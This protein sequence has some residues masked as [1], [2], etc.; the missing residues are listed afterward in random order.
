MPEDQR[1]EL[2]RN[3]SLD[4][5]L[6]VLRNSREYVLFC[7]VMEN[8]V[9]RDK[10]MRF[11]FFDKERNIL[12]LT[13]TDIMEV[14]EEERQRQLLQDALQVAKSANQAKSDFLSRMSHDI[15]TPMNAIIGMTTIASMHIDDRERIVDCLKK[16]MVSSKLLLNLI[17][18]VLDMSKVESG[19]ILLTDEEFDMGELLQSVITMVQTSVSQKFQDFRV[20][21]F[22]VKHEKLIGDVQRIQQV[23]LNLLSNAIKYTPD[24]GK[25]TLEIREKPIKMVI[26]VY[27]R[28]RL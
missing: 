26:M 13:R 25:I 21:L 11:S 1:D 5:V 3:L 24:Y 20:H 12:L 9:F 23:L 16:I 2:T 7:Q 27:L 8:G 22:Q 4:H 18:E 15:R 14:R 6:S 28:L 17:N 10:K 19:H